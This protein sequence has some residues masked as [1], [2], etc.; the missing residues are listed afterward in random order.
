LTHDEQNGV[1]IRPRAV[2]SLSFSVVLTGDPTVAVAAAA[3]A[4][5]DTTPSWLAIS[6]TVT[7]GGRRAHPAQRVFL[8]GEE[9]M[10]GAVTSGQ[11]PGGRKRARPFALV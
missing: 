9:R 1:R 4:A 3:A 10:A 6:R 5:P 7:V 2:G 11:T 8:A